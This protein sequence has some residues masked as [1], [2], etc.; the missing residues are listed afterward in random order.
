MYIYLPFFFP[1]YFLFLSSSLSLTNTTFINMAQFDLSIQSFTPPTIPE[2][3]PDIPPSA[4]KSPHL[5]SPVP[6]TSPLAF[7]VS[8]PSAR[9]KNP[10]FPATHLQMTYSF[11]GTGEIFM[12]TLITSKDLV[13]LDTGADAESTLFQVRIDPK[14]I[15]RPKV[16]HETTTDAHV[17]VYAWKREKLLGKWDVGDV[18]GLGI[19]GLKS[20][21]LAVLRQ[22]TWAAQRES[23]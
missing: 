20:N 18:E 3:P 8:L 19:S 12:T 15:P 13:K 1:Y 14:D 17:R 22:Q 21:D 23:K 2:T 7:S 6:V 5:P 9:D 10:L 16:N 4:F 11:E